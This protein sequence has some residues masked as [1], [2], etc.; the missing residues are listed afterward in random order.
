MES[1][2]FLIKI[3]DKNYIK[4]NNNEIL[5]IFKISLGNNKINLQYNKSKI[6]FLNKNFEII[7]NKQYIERNIGKMKYRKIENK[8]EIKILHNIFIS[9]NIK[10]AKIIIKNKQYDLKE[11]IDSSIYKVKIK[12]V[13]NIIHLNSMFSD[14]KSLSSVDNLQYFN[15]KYLRTINYST[16]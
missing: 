8:K 5:D 12:F 9:N 3:K 10:R 15:T 7:Y 14:C 4:F 16:E 11:N 13:D 1:N 6:Q 2:F